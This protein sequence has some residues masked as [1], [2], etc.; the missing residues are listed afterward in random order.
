[1]SVLLCILFSLVSCKY[2]PPE[3]AR[4]AY[5]HGKPLILYKRLSIDNLGIM[6]LNNIQKRLL[7]GHN[8]QQSQNIQNWNNNRNTTIQTNWG[9][10]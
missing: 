3:A 9:M 8:R 6:A 2:L 7:K 5:F 10:W 1:M 4:G